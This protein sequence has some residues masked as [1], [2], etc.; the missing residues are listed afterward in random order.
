MDTGIT[1]N[2]VG[3][4]VIDTFVIGLASSAKYIFAGSN[5]GRIFHSTD[6]GDTWIQIQT[7][8]LNETVF[9]FDIHPNGH[10][11]AST[12]K[13]GIFRS[14]DNGDQWT[15]IGFKDTI[16]T[17]AVNSS[18]ILF[19]GTPDYGVFRSSD[20]GV[21]WTPTNSGLTNLQVR[22]IGIYSNGY[23]FIGTNGGPVFASLQT[24]TS[25]DLKVDELP[26]QY[27][28]NQN[29][30]NPFNPITTI[31][32]SLP[33]RSLVQIK[34]FTVLGKEIAVLVNEEQITGNHK[35]EFNGT[36]LP[37]GV[38]FYRLTTGDF[39]DTKKL[40]LLK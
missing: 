5:N 38:Y 28:L 3:E 35:I 8:S 30:P 7:D 24:T 1:W 6:F 23:V 14:T 29:F 37:S 40:I 16:T 2:R 20:E 26:Q 10:I 31:S 12:Y 39:T 4:S 33:K 9:G 34:I 22:S 21:T 36:N 11:F 18:G 19:V 17:L 32:Y 13:G 15:Y 25:A 27:F